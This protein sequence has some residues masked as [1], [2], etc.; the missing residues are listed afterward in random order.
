M[1]TFRNA[2][3]AGATAVALTFGG[4]SVA[5]AAPEEQGTPASSQDTT[6]NP[7]LSSWVGQNIFNIGEHGSDTDKIDGGALFGSSKDWDEVND[8]GKRLYILTAILGV[9]AVASLLIAPVY[10][11]V[12]FG[13]FAQ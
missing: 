12:K 2:A 6:Q 8:A 10:N 4:A 13:P 11:F 7:G 1:R 9:S 3:L 5:T